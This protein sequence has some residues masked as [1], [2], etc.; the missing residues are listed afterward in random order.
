MST[1]ESLTVPVCAGCARAVYP[2]RAL[3]PG[4]GGDRW[5]PTV[6]LD[7]VLETTTVLRKVAGSDDGK[8]IRLGTVRLDSGVRVV[9]RVKGGVTRGA[10]AA[11][12]LTDGVV[13]ARRRK[14][15][16]S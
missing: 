2:P 8:P 13:V 15:G 5:R 16:R 10:R 11:L 4:C 14:G 9:T 12:R 6:V 3:C 7:G 1:H